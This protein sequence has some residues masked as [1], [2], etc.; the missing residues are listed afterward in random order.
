MSHLTNIGSGVSLFNQAPI[1][2]ESCTAKNANILM[3]KLK[4]IDIVTDQLYK[5]PD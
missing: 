2:L 3:I 5:N 4:I 1:S